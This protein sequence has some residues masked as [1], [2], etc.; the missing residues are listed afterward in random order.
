MIGLAALISVR[1]SPFDLAIALA[2]LASGMR[3]RIH[4]VASAHRQR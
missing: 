2:S 1:K 4:F 3:G